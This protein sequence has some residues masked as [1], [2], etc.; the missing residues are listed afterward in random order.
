MRIGVVF[1]G[2]DLHLPT[3]EHAVPVGVV[4][5]GV[6]WVLERTRNKEH[7]LPV[8]QSVVIGVGLV[9]VGQEIVSASHHFLAVFKAVVVRVE[10][11]RDWWSRPR[12]PT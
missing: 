9:S 8:N 2:F 12:L 3:V 5:E 10:H 4:Q 6:G 7:F 11:A 1:G